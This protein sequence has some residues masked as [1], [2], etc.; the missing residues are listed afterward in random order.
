MYLLSLTDIQL[1][2]STTQ[3]LRGLPS[4]CWTPQL[5]RLQELACWLL[6]LLCHLTEQC[7]ERGNLS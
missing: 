5:T 7:I 4:L 3:G 2:H 1:L 6:D